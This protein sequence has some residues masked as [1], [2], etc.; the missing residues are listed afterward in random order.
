MADKELQDIELKEFINTL[1]HSEPSTSLAKKIIV[2][3]QEIVQDKIIYE[4][5]L[6]FKSELV[7]I[8]NTVS[9]G[10]PWI[11]LLLVFLLGLAIAFLARPEII[12]FSHLHDYF[13]FKGEI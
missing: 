10:K 3:S 4:Q 13:S 11:F 9:F 6:D 8:L 5:D 1:D 2:Q 7:Q 12:D